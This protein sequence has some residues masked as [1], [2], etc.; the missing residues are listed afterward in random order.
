MRTLGVDP[1]EKRIG[2][3]VSDEEGILARPLRVLERTS[4]KND[5][6]ELRSIVDELQIERIVIGHPVNMN[7]SEGPQA[8]RAERLAE[9]TREQVPVPVVLRDERLSTQTALDLR[10]TTGKRRGRKR[11]GIDAVAAAVILQSYLDSERAK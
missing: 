1:G 6:A 5:L 4:W 7:G 9:R 2:L 10:K 11:S 8:R 3:A